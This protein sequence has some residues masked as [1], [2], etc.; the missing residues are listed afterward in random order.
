MP[1]TNNNSNLNA[2]SGHLKG[3]DPKVDQNFGIYVA[4]APGQL[5]T[6]LVKV[7]AVKKGEL[8]AFQSRN[9][10]LKSAASLLACIPVRA[11]SIQ[12]IRGGGWKA[13]EDMLGAALVNEGMTQC[14][15]LFFG[16]G[17]SALDAA[18]VVEAALVRM[19]RTFEPI[20][21]QSIAEQAR[22]KN[23]DT[24]AKIQCLIPTPE[25]CPFEAFHNR[26][27]APR[28]GF[29]EGI[30]ENRV[31]M[32]ELATLGYLALDMATGIGMDPLT[33]WADDQSHL[34]LYPHRTLAQALFEARCE[35]NLYL[36]SKGRIDV[37]VDDRSWVCDRP[38]AMT[39]S[40]KDVLGKE[41]PAALEPVPELGQDRWR[42]RAEH[43]AAL[44]D[45][46]VVTE[47][48]P[49]FFAAHTRAPLPPEVYALAMRDPELLPSLRFWVGLLSA[50]K[51]DIRV[52]DYR[53]PR[54]P[55]RVLRHLGKAAQSLQ[56]IG[57]RLSKEQ[58]VIGRN[59]WR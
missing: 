26:Y 48:T 58:V 3:F 13:T 56:R 6:N 8:K 55:S 57:L 11:F 41:I 54:L 45:R 43:L 9:S 1:T 5:V 34:R 51:Q 36:P 14:G 24:M 7:G 46:A 59:M 44:G 15:E 37:R 49:H 23:R 21:I 17:R 18:D 2:E 50:W 33:F 20:D 31:R 28:V 39:L 30:P 32:R 22:E 12:P 35:Q 4:E 53:L 16:S 38:Q 40:Y 52:Q 42:F 25:T 47:V 27:D 29:E 19:G 10:G